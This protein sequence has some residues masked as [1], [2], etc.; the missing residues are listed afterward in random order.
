MKDQMNKKARIGLTL[1]ILT[2]V[3]L[4]STFWAINYSPTHSMWKPRE[5]RE[6]PKQ[7]NRESYHPIPGDIEFYYT[8]K[9]VISTI[10]VTLLIFLLA[11]Y[12]SI[13][14]ETRSEFTIGLIIFSI[15]LLLYALVSNP[16]VHQIFGFGALG[17]GP[18]AMLPD[19]F[20]CMALSVL[21]YLT[22]KY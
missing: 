19:L 1:T 8:A 22:F 12:S 21:L 4:L 17:L 20:T 13:Y 5:P 9:T 16:L 18:F 15:I 7:W 3:A 11:M 10:N 2:V 14:V 6:P